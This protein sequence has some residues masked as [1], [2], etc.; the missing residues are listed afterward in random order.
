MIRLHRPA[1]APTRRD[2]LWLIAG[3]WLALLTVP[4]AALAQ[5]GAVTSTAQALNPSDSGT[6]AALTKFLT[7]ILRRVISGEKQVATWVP[8]V[9]AA[10]LGPLITALLAVASGM[11]LTDGRVVAGV[12]I[13]GGLLA[14]TGGAVLLTAGHAMSRDPAANIPTVLAGVPSQQ[15]AQLCCMHADC[16]TVQQAMTQVASGQPAVPVE[17]AQAVP[18]SPPNPPP[19]NPPGSPG[20]GVVGTV[21]LATNVAPVRPAGPWNQ[22]R[23]GG[24]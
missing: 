21:P 2:L 5:V 18:T 15:R 3:Y 12:V 17:A 9:I 13:I 23:Q 19:A 8:L 14:A 4:H 16:R 7:D 22:Y 20:V 1:W 24:A 10:V 6:A 11:D